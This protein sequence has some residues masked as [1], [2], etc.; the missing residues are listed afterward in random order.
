MTERFFWLP[1]CICPSV[2]IGVNFVTGFSPIPSHHQPLP[3]P[4][5]HG[6]PPPAIPPS[7]HRRYSPAQR[8]RR[9]SGTQRAGRAPGAAR[10]NAGMRPGRLGGRRIVVGFLVGWL[11]PSP[12]KGPGGMFRSCRMPTPRV[13]PVEGVVF[14]QKKIS[15][16]PSPRR[17]SGRPIRIIQHLKLVHQILQCHFPANSSRQC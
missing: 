8:T 11:P 10:P 14:L 5:S 15:G 17:W 9:A 2:V 6:P 7:P 3:P 16:G 13:G 4:P 12:G 1:F